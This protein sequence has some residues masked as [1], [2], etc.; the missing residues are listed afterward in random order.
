M[1]KIV[2]LGSSG[3]IGRNVL[4]VIDE[5][6][7]EFKVL[8]LAVKENIGLLLK[9][10]KKFKPDYVAVFN[11]DYIGYL[12]KKLKG[13]RIK[14]LGGEEGLKELCRLK[15]ADLIVN[16]VVGSA[17]LKYTLEA[18]ENRKNIA[19]ANKE[20]LVM[21]GEILTRLAKK[22][23]VKIIPVDSEHNAIFNLISNRKFE[24]IEKIILTA[25]GGPF[26]LFR[27]IDL[28]NVS[29]IEALR[30][31]VWR[32]GNKI[33]IDSATLANKGFEIIEAHHLFNI[34]YERI[35]VL[36]HP[37]SIIHSMIQT[38]DGSIYAQLSL[39]DMKFP[40]LNALS[41][42]EIFKNPFKKIDFRKFN[43]LT[44]EMPDYDRFPLLKYSYE[45]GKK[46]GNMP[47]AFVVADEIAVSM[48]LNRKIKF[49]KIYKLI[50]EIVESTK[51]I[52]N[53]TIKDIF[54]TEREIYAKF[55]F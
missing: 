45:I 43:R 40:I 37:Q 53:P 54:N 4:E 2:L 39:P 9:Q 5:F 51:Y 32:M 3:S 36:I 35:E 44:F 26:R 1:K 48:F 33:T 18:L 13:E 50:K 17:G 14:V 6:K 46:G 27:K 21:A 31:P 15:E 30:H 29:P 20:S 47:A 8:A 23:K 38:V 49:N 7:N 25:S 24:T 22:N 19:L 55:N 41:Y 34:D 10:V 11:K 42:P 16:A 28:R 12:S 52:E